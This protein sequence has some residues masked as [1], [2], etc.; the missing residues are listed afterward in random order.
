MVY[1]ARSLFSYQKAVFPHLVIP[2]AK[3]VAIH[4]LSIN[5]PHPPSASPEP[6][7][8]AAS[9]APLP[10]RNDKECVV[11]ARAESPWRSTGFHQPHRILRLRHPR[12]DGLPRPSLAFS[13]R[14]DKTPCHR[15]LSLCLSSRGLKAR[16]DPLVL[17]NRT[18]KPARIPRAMMDC[19]VPHL[20]SLLAMTK[21]GVSF[22]RMAGF[23]A[24]TIFTSFVLI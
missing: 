10:P 5:E 17:N 18:D 14:N 4:W 7:W 13:P 2:R 11:I 23:R 3:P 16:G 24:C 6:P 9:L 8:I 15:D 21:G 1:L 22:Y 20:R 19:R 12:P